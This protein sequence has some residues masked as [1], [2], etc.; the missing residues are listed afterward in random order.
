MICTRFLGLVRPRILSLGSKDKFMGPETIRFWR[1]VIILI[2][3]EL[4]VEEPSGRQK[5]V[6]WIWRTDFQE[7]WSYQ[8]QYKYYKFGASYGI[9]QYDVD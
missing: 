7:R 9:S 4:E 6:F 5:F 8:K 2:A 3:S 1:W